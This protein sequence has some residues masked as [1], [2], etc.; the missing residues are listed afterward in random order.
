M[1][2]LLKVLID[3]QIINQ[4]LALR[5][6]KEAEV[7]ERNV[8][9]IIYD[10]KIV[11]EK[12]V[13]KIKGKIFGL[14]VKFL[15]KDEKIPSEIVN[16]I[17]E[18]VARNYKIAALAKTPDKFSVGMVYPDDKRAQEALRFISQKLQAELEIFIITPGD[19][20]NIRKNYQMFA[21]EIE[22]AL[23]ALKKRGG[24]LTEQEKSLTLDQL[25]M[26]AGEE[27]PIIK[28]VSSLLKCGVEQ[29]A[30]DIHIEPLSQKLRVRYRLD[31]VLHSTLFLPL[32]IHP[33]VISR[34]KILSNLKIDENRI[35]QDGRF[36][37]RINEKD[38]DFRVS[39]LPTAYGEKVAI[40]ILDPSKGLFDLQDIA[41]N[42]QNRKI[43]ERAINGPFGM[44]LMTGPTGCGKTTTLYAILRTINKD[45]VNII[46]LEDPVEYS[47]EGINQSQVRPEINYT[48]A[49][50]LRQILR[51][52]PDIIMVGEIRDSETAELAVHAALT[53]HLVFAT[54]HTNNAIGVIPRL[55]DLGIKPFLLPSSLKLMEAQRL[56]PI[57]CPDCRFKVKAEGEIEIAIKRAIDALPEVFKK[58]ITFKPPYEIYETQGCPKCFY[59]GVK[60]RIGIFELFEMTPNLE[61][62]ISSGITESNL[63]EEAK[64]Q[65]MITMRQDG[66]LKALEGLVS[67]GAVLKET[68]E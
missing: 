37:A 6:E 58:Q 31:G 32:L 62:I 66:I 20:Q 52:N 33:S 46:S 28:I 43:V 63:I 11:D 48:F 13:A 3:N 9:E 55:I 34:I 5:I 36:K 49:S 29:A 59:R 60:S 45:S 10:K 54:L 56:L 1:H 21:T 22:A 35:P 68:N 44:I 12:T 24:L 4:D 27:A 8:E 23:V 57:L 38:I 65:G 61:R 67:I 14:P 30:S 25:A 2:S 42:A 26:S 47:L 17:P 50:G 64:N 18:N 53:G 16:L 51:Q 39:T 19:L 40:R 15:A 7:L 41:F